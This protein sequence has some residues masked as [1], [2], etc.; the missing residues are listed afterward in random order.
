MSWVMHQKWDG[1][2]CQIWFTE[3]LKFAESH[4]TRGAILRC[5]VLYTLI[6]QLQDCFNRRRQ[7][8]CGSTADKRN[9]MYFT[10]WK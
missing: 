9:Y 7:G 2:N 6:T 4:C 8:R 5:S 10:I 3:G 1:N